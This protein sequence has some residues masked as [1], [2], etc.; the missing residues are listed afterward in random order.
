MGATTAMKGTLIA[1]NGAVFVAAGSTIIGRL[2]S[3]TGAVNID[4]STLTI[5]TSCIYLDL[6]VLS[7]FAMFTSVGAVGNTGSSN[8]TGDIGTNTGA[9]TGFGT[10]TVNGTIYEAGSGTCSG[11]FSIYQNGVL[12]ANSSRTRTSSLSTADITL[13]AIATVAAGQAIDVRWR[14][15]HGAL[16][17]G[18]RRLTLTKVQ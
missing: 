16:T 7:T 14:T 5:P 3:T 15:D 4:G 2:F 13:Q 10:V 12:V 6:G 11:I 1:N 18:S 17:L 8:I 9:I